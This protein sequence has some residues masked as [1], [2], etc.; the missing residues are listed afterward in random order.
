MLE[1][2]DISD[3]DVRLDLHPRIAPYFILL[4]YCRHI[5]FQKQSKADSCWIARV[6]KKDGGYKQHRLGCSGKLSFEQ[7]VCA[8]ESWFA[9]RDVSAI[10][11]EPY[12]IGSKRNLSICPMG[13]T[14]TVGSAMKAYLEWKAM[15]A[16][17]SHFETLVSLINYYVVPNLAFIPL[18]EFNGKH[19]GDF[20]LHVIETPPKRGRDD[21]I[22][23]NRLSELSQEALRKRKK[24]LNA[25]I[26]ILRGAFLLAWERGDIRDDRPMRCLRRL[27]NVDRPRVIFLDRKQCRALLSAC[28]DDLEMLVRAALYTGCRAN[29]LCKML[30]ED[31]NTSGPA[32]F[33][34]S[35]KG[36]RQRYVFLPPEG[37]SFF[38]EISGDRAPSDFLFRKTNGRRWGAEY[39]SYFQKARRLAGLQEQLTFHGLRHTYASQLIQGGASLLSVAEQLGHRNVQAVS[40]TYGHLCAYQ[41]EEEVRRSFEPLLLDVAKKEKLEKSKTAPMF[42]HHK[43]VSWPRSNHARFSG[44]LLQ[45]LR[46]AEQTEDRSN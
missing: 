16:T 12:Q 11:A 9:R 17:R 46:M 3:P 15:A 10:A 14:P 25:I 8:A 24:T 41:R 28:S 29:E 21:P 18:E 7:A 36:V 45:R 30:V 44:P 26:S 34:S 22:G 2:P 27:P 32:V 40:S 33:V 31:L 23:R 1:R 6:R 4:S 43:D 39:K 5:G 42:K 37:L 20:C 38:R 35:L 13:D 19:F